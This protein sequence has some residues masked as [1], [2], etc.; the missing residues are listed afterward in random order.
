MHKQQTA[1]THIQRTSNSI[2]WTTTQRRQN[3]QR[4]PQDHS[5]SLLLLAA[6][7]YAL[8]SHSHATLLCK[9]SYLYPHKTASIGN[10]DAAGEENSPR[11]ITQHYICTQNMHYSILCCISIEWLYGNGLKAFRF[12]WLHAKNNRIW[13]QKYYSFIVDLCLSQKGSNDDIFTILSKTKHIFTTH[14]Y[15]VIRVEYAWGSL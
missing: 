4:R 5:L 2:A 9:Y 8:K 13:M 11:T 10:I 12:K 15:R 3:I 6:Q 1:L 7:M 14:S